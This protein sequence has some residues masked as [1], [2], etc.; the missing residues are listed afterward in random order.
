MA[1]AGP[2]LEDVGGHGFH[3]EDSIVALPRESRSARACVQELEW[4]PSRRSRRRWRTE[5][6]RDVRQSISGSSSVGGPFGGTADRI[7]AS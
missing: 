1:V 5:A 2:V 7:G 3:E 6:A 4:C